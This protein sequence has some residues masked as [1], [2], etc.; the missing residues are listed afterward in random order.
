MGA[1]AEMGFALMREIV[2]ASM[3]RMHFAQLRLAEEQQ[4]ELVI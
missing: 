2:K 1:D 4:P 3:E